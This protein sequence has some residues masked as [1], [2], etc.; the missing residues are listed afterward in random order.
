MVEQVLLDLDGV[1]VDFVKG[2]CK[3][4]GRDNPYEASSNHHGLFD[5]D[6][7]WEMTASDFW[8]PC[9]YDFWM[10][11]EFHEEAAEILEILSVTP[12]WNAV[13]ILTSPCDT[14]GCVEGKRDWIRK[15]LPDFSK[16]LLIGSAKEFQTNGNKRLLI[17]DRNE[18]VAKFRSAG[19]LAYTFPR[20]W[21][22]GRFE[23]APWQKSLK[24]ML[25]G[26]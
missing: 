4:H 23:S 21:N 13:C 19:G 5:M 16:R 14:A 8:S 18:N 12:G 11:L 15:N 1:I 7:I 22:D 17:D 20:P 24:S 2:I 9:G 26:G 10:G 25:T 6:K 3:L